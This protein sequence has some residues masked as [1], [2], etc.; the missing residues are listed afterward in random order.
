MRKILKKKDIEK[1]YIYLKNLHCSIQENKDNLT[2]KELNELYGENYI[3]PFF[4]QNYGRIF[5]FSQFWVNKLIQLDA[6]VGEQRAKR[7]KE[8]ETWSQGCSRTWRNNERKY[9]KM[10]LN[11]IFKEENK[12]CK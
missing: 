9:D 4:V 2:L 8:T 6:F 1:D 10:L 11:Q 7:K 12:N 3:P 5:P